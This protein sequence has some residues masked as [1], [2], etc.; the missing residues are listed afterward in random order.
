[1][2]KK[3]KIVQ[4]ITTKITQKGQVFFL[5]FALFTL[6]FALC[7]L[8]SAAEVTTVY[9]V[10][11]LSGQHFY[12]GDMS[13]V[14]GNIN[15]M[16]SPSVTLTDK[17]SV[18]TTYTGGYQGTRNV[19]E[20][21]GGGTLFHDSMYHGLTCK[22]IYNLGSSWKI[23]PTI[24]ARNE[25]LRETKDESWSSG[26]FDYMKYTGGV[27]TEY[28]YSKEIGARLAYDYYTLKFPNY[29]SLES[30]QSATLSREL[31]GADVLNSGNHLLTLG[32]WAR[33]L[34]RARAE[35]TFFYNLRNYQDQPIAVNLSDLSGSDRKDKTMALQTVVSYPWAMG[36]QW[37]FVGD[38][39][40]SWNATNSD[41][42][43]ADAQQNEFIKDYYDYSE[44]SVS[45][46][47]TAAMGSK[48]W[49]FSVS[50]SYTKRNYSKRPIQDSDGAYLTAKTKM[51][52]IST[53]F[54]VSY[55]IADNFKARFISTLAWA[56]SNMKY[57]SVYKYNYKISNYLF[58][59]T[60]EY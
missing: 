42:N 26:L 55:P 19:Q 2:N 31:V 36:S 52:E 24:G 17:W 13:S 21:A 47:V 5:P 3:N 49:V 28:A 22:G 60:Y 18:L 53:A 23:K 48:P 51:T 8:L 50:A 9:D 37:R 40:F 11:F 20:L 44:I 57:E 33:F 46:G 35:M 32:G 15:V 41:Q 54:G 39:G 14:S 56:D 10:R 27:E 16:V 29:E 25:Y 45:P 34:G 43:R 6:L 4:Y 30:W 12:D 1:M 59:F 58:G 38:L 7:P